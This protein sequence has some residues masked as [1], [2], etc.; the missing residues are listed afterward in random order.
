MPLS[1]VERS[2]QRYA[3]LAGFLYLAIILLGGF[4]ELFV[5]G[6][7]VVSGDAAATAD[8]ILHS[9]FLWRAGIAGDLLMHVFDVPVI[10]ILYFLLRPVSRSLALLATLI[11]LVQ[12][13][14]LVANKL[15]L[16]LPLFLLEDAGQLKAFSAEQLHALSYLAIKAHGVGFGIGLIFFGVACLVRGYLIFRS[17][18]FPRPLG[19]LVFVAGLSYLTNSF[20]LLLA[21]S[22]AAS[23]FP[24]VLI[25]A[26]VGELSF[27][28][29]LIVK[30]VDL[31]QRH[32]ISRFGNHSVSPGQ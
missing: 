6:T 11:N 23:I 8:N 31:E 19:V 13:A 10:L 17:G 20:A 1:P 26:F 2:P 16:L 30:G 9:P 24:G 18:Y 15:N 4:G 25:P 27:C 32:F 7:L 21:P 12:T 28:L 14:V 29:W 3:R 5:R 22:I